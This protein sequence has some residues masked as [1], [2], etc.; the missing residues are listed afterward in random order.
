MEAEALDV[1]ADPAM[2]R[3]WQ[4]EVEAADL[5]GAA[6][7]GTGRVLGFSSHRQ[8]GLKHVSRFK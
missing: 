5:A 8:E 7:F 1:I 2:G 3:K 4:P 6:S